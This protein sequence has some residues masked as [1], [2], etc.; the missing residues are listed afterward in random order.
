MSKPLT[1][2][3]VGYER[4]YEDVCERFG[5]DNAFRFFNHHAELVVRPLGRSLVEQ[6]VDH[7]LMAKSAHRVS[8]RDLFYAQA[9]AYSQAAAEVLGIPTPTVAEEEEG[10]VD[11]DLLRVADDLW[12]RSSTIIPEMIVD[13]VM[14]AVD[15]VKAHGLPKEV[16]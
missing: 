7:L 8:A 16:V 13:E 4:I 6:M 2:Q 15:N 5:G 3:I 14:Q 10:Y 11:L 1:D 12:R 9:G